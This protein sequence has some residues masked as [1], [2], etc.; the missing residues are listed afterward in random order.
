[1]PYPFFLLHFIPS[2]AKDTIPLLLNMLRKLF[3][4]R[5]F[6]KC[7]ILGRLKRHETLLR[8]PSPSQQGAMGQGGGVPVEKPG[9]AN[10][11]SVLLK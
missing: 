11:Q 3:V 4:T 1:M 8:L 10:S 9:R 5:L 6:T 7:L 2:F